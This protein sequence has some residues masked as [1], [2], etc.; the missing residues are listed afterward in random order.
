M[1]TL[2]ASFRCKI[3]K[4]FFTLDLTRELSLFWNRTLT[5]FLSKDLFVSLHDSFCL[6]SSDI[7][8][9]QM[10]FVLICSLQLFGRERVSLQQ[11][12]SSHY[13]DAV[14]I[15]IELCG[16]L[17]PFQCSYIALGIR[18]I[19][20]SLHFAFKTFDFWFS[21]FVQSNFEVAPN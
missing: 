8:F 9:Q 6:K 17:M 13:F 3:F 14:C 7:F 11:N 2:K 16:S 19:K 15:I 4:Q 12:R 20:I 1:H 18:K 10:S 21:N 5:D